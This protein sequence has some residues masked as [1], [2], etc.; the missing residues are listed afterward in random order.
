MQGYLQKITGAQ[1]PIVH[2]RSED[3]PVAIYIGKS[4]G[5]DALGITDEGLS[6]DAYRMVSGPDYLALLGYDADF[7]PDELMARTM[8]HKRNDRERAQKAWEE[9]SGTTGH[10]PGGGYFKALHQP[11][12]IWTMDKGG[13]LQAVYGFLRDLGVRWYMPGELGEVVPQ[14]NSIDLPVVDQT[15][16]PDYAY[17]DLRLGNA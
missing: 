14:R 13:S 12:G 2:E 16:T 3:Y 15:V 5:T 10:S 8:A 11:S 6:A 9:L 7:E 4:A 17:R 1:L